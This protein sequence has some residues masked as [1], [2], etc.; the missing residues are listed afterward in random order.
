MAGAMIVDCHTHIWQGSGGA[1]A[2]V[3]GMDDN[4]IDQALVMALEPGDPRVGAAPTDWVLQEAHSF[5]DRLK[6]FACVHPLA[7]GA[8]DRL[9]HYVE[10]EGCCGLK[11][12]PPLQHFSLQDPGI[13][14]VLHVAAELGVPV[15]VHTGPILVRHARLRYGAAI[16]IDELALT[17]PDTTFIVAHGDPLGDA[18]TLVGKHPNVYMDTS[19][20]FARMAKVM[21]N[22]L[23]ETLNWVA[24]WTAVNKILFGTDA[25]PPRIHRIKETLAVLL[26]ASVDAAP[27]EKVLGATTLALL[28]SA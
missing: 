8:Q 25:S 2:L 14:P 16:D 28:G 6:V 4:G 24:Q 15:L 1:D 10:D 27:L 3:R 13:L 12:H 9:R 7:P 22:L 26:A 19:I 20:V 23:G 17:C 5:P 21:P 18:G 11:L